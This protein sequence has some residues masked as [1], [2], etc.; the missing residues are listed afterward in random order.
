M[1]YVYDRFPVDRNYW[2][3]RAVDGYVLYAHLKDPMG[4]FAVRTF[5]I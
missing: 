4:A 5:G 2:S 1:E 3:M